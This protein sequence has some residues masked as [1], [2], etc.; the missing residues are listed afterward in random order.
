M[1]TAAIA[2]ALVA[3]TAGL[4]ASEATITVGYVSPVGAQPGQQQVNLGLRRAAKSMGWNVKILDANLSSDRQVSMIDTLITQKVNA[5][6]TWTLDPNAVAGVY[7]RAKAATIPIIGTNSVGNGIVGTVWWQI[8]TCFPG[9]PWEQQAKWIAARRPGAN[10]IAMGGPPVPVLKLIKKCF[11]NAAKA[12]GLKIVGQADNVNDNS[13]TGQQ[14]AADLLTRYPD[15]Q[16]I[17]AYNDSTALGASAAILGANKKVARASDK[18]GIMVFGANADAEAI[19]AVRAGRLTGTWDPDTL[20]TGFAIARLMAAALKNP[21]KRVP[22]L[23]IKSVLYTS[24]N[25]K[26]YVPPAKRAYSMNKI[27]LVKSKS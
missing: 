9:G 8:D 6:G 25:I 27:P 12:A 14:L 24:D 26:T 1:S 4:S 11:M 18:D 3:A 17:W 7:A 21:G 19:E 16:V 22:D 5:M 2:A 13:A 15:T 23:T 20:A 10:V